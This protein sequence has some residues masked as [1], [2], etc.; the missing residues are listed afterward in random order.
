MKMKKMK[1]NQKTEAVGI[2]LL[3][4]SSF[5]FYEFTY[6]SLPNFK[7]IILDLTKIFL[8]LLFL[9]AIF[10]NLYRLKFRNFFLFIYLIYISIFTLKLFFN[11]SDVITLHLFIEKTF[12]YFIKWDLYNKPISIK[13]VSYLTP[14]ILIIFFLIFL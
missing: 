7:T 9:N 10:L 12:Y 11:A 3:L 5:Y 14:F 13:I 1:I 6:L 2:S 8:L 4:L